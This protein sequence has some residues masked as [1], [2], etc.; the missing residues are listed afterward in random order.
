[1][2]RRPRAGV[3]VVAS[4]TRD[5]N[6]TPTQHRCMHRLPCCLGRAGPCALPPHARL[7][8]LPLAARP[9]AAQRATALLH[10]ALC[11]Y[12]PQHRLPRCCN[13]LHHVMG[14]PSRVTAV[15]LFSPLVPHCP[16][17]RHTQ[18]ASR[19]QHFQLIPY[20]LQATAHMRSPCRSFYGACAAVTGPR[21][22]SHTPHRQLSSGAP[23]AGPHAE[24][25]RPSGC[26]RLT[27]LGHQCRGLPCPCSPIVAFKVRHHL[28]H[29]WDP[30]A[31]RLPPLPGRSWP[32]L[33]G[34][35][36]LLLQPPRRC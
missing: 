22:P 28:T 12:A 24:P 17:P 6:P 5:T 36:L 27:V 21:Q 3:L 33:R 32:L 15:L 25:P 14:R 11:S 8:V 13:A 2:I 30:Q 26:L 34:A 9:L 1:M 35:H 29:A 19:H 16:T 18:R 31:F 7:P 10:T 23:P 20:M 4:D